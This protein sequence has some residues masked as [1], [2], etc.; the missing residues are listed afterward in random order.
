M[1]K[2]FENLFKKPVENSMIYRLQA[3]TKDIFTFFSFLDDLNGF[4]TQFIN[5][6]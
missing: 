3:S 5:S 6:I 2:S 1:F 4:S